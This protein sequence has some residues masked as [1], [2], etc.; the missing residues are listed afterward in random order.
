MINISRNKLQFIRFIINPNYLKTLNPISLISSNPPSL[1]SPIHTPFYIHRCFSAI[2]NQN[3]TKNPSQITLDFSPKFVSLVI[4]AVRSNNPNCRFKLDSINRPLTKLSI[5]QIFTVLSCEKVPALQFFEWVRENNSDLYRNSEV[6]SLMIDNCGW[7]DDYET[8]TD[9]LKEFR[10]EGICL[11]DKAFGFLPVLD[12]SKAKSM[13]CIELVVRVLDQVGGSVRSSGVFALINFLCGIDCF[14][15]AK[16]VIEITEKKLNYYAILVR[17]KCKRGC[18]DEAYD[19]LDEIKTAGCEVDSK[20]YNYILGS[21]CKSDNLSQA[22]TLLE[23]M[24]ETGVDPD[25]ITFEI[26][27]TNSCRLGRME[28]AKESLNRLIKMGR[29][30][31]VSTHVAVVKGY[32]NAGRY[33]EA[34]EYVRDMEVKKMPAVNKMYSLLARMHQKKGNVDVSRR[35]LNEMMEKG[36]KPDFTYYAKTV[37]MLRRT[38]GKDLAR[39][40]QK[41][42]SQFRIE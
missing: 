15:F 22:L 7:L 5:C 1:S 42:F 14:E 3:V 27:I 8:M 33:D 28:F 32:C 35:I 30:P 13:E 26:F 39:D 10:R 38:G 17:E 16:F 31:R 6:C 12:S 21:L 18:S 11:S 20:I 37:N 19:L 25:E 34:H 2:S 23:E 24:K 9:L 41:K 36:L 4:D 40:L 29:T